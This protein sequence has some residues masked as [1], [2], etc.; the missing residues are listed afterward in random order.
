MATTQ[1]PPVNEINVNVGPFRNEPM[2]DFSK[3]ENLQAM[4]TAIEKIR[5]E[6]GREYPLIIGGKMVITKDML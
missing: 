3:P 4:K 5:G 2:T 6:L 1:A